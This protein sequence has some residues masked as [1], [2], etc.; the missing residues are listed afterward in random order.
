MADVD[1]TSLLTELDARLKDDAH[2]AALETCDRILSLAPTD[3]DV[4]HSKLVCQVELSNRPGAAYAGP[5]R[6]CCAAKRAL[7]GS[8]YDQPHSA[9]RRPRRRPAAP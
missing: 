2:E 1:L 6:C 9:T 7:G 3:T 5:I 8:S 4:L